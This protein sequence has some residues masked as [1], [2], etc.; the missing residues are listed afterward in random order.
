MF[1]KIREA[2]ADLASKVLSKES[3]QSIAQN[4]MNR[5]MAVARFGISGY[6]WNNVAQPNEE[7]RW[8]AKDYKGNTFSPEIPDSDFSANFS[9]YQ[10][11]AGQLFKE[12]NPDYNQAQQ[13]RNVQNS[14]MP[15]SMDDIKGLI[16]SSISSDSSK[17]QS[18]QS[19]NHL[20]TGPSDDVNI[21]VFMKSGSYVME[22]GKLVASNQKPEGLNVVSILSAAPAEDGKPKNKLRGP[23]L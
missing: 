9:Q 16:Q 23:G 18:L 19:R 3:V 14:M 13:E 11:T 22:N 1:K 15:R 5:Q 17:A 12:K 8:V 20:N 6:T 7:A 10:K 4:E 21:S 2:A